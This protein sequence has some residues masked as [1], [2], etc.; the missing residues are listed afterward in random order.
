[1]TATKR[2]DGVFAPH[3]SYR[4]HEAEGGP[5][6]V[7]SH[8]K[9]YKYRVGKKSIIVIH[10]HQKATAAAEQGNVLASNAVN[11]QIVHKHKG[12]KKRR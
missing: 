6:M 10:I 7:R 11:V 9:T 4:E 8:V 3:V 12:R 1:M 5:V 2:R